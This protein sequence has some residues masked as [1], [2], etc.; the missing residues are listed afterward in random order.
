MKRITTIIAAGLLTLGLGT[1]N[2]QDDAASMSEL[3]NLIEQGQARD[4]QE[5]R[6]REAQFQQ[7]RNQQQ[8]LLNR[9]RAER[10]RQE[11]I[12]ARLEQTFE[13][14]ELRIADKQKQL[15]A[16]DEYLQTVR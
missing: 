14:N 12:S 8:T 10:T 2:A 13:E 16:L 1:A 3:L 9:A 15:K 6:Q 7:Q 4:S 5:A 11:N